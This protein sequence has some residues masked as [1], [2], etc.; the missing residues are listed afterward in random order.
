MI[1][2][3][4]AIAFVLSSFATTRAASRS[5]LALRE[6]RLGLLGE[7]GL[8]LR[9]RLRRP[10][11]VGAREQLAQ[12]CQR[13]W[14]LGIDRVGLPVGLLRAPGVALPEEHRAQVVVGL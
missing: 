2:R 14:V 4:R 1:S 12:R 3:R 10:G 13:P 11:I 8:D 7:A 9:L 6:Q 5:R